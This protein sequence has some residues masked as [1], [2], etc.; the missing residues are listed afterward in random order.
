MSPRRRCERRAR[1]RCPRRVQPASGCQIRRDPRPLIPWWLVPSLAAR[2]PCHCAWQD[3]TLLAGTTNG[4]VLLFDLRTGRFERRLAH[5]D[6]CNALAVSGHYLVSA[7]DDKLVRIS[8]LRKH[9]FQS[10]GAHRVRS[11]VFAACADTEAIYAGCD[12]GD[13]ATAAS[14]AT[15]SPTLASPCAAHARTCTPWFASPRPRHLRTAIAP[16]GLALSRRSALSLCWQC[17]YLTTAPKPTPRRL[18]PARA[19]SPDSRRQGSRQRSRRYSAAARVGQ[20]IALL[21]VY[22]QLRADVVHPSES[23]RS[24][25]GPLYVHEGMMQE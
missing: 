18:A 22:G 9:S 13:G 2:A 19:A 1:L 5:A 6:C 17:A 21:A 24:I 8:D 25:K 11:V 3:T 7:G 12:A 20:P 15:A 4:W 23:D 16:Q 14:H 10:L